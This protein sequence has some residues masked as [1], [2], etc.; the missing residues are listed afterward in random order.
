MAEYR[1]P[2]PAIFAGLLEAALEK[3]LVLDPLSAERLLRL[4]GRCLQVNLEGLGIGLFLT[5]ESGNLRVNLDSDR[6]PDTV[7]TATPSALFSMAAPGEP[8]DWG[9]P[10]SSVHITGDA[11]LARELERIFSKLEPDWQQPLNAVL[12]DT[13][14]FQVA[15]GLR[16]GIQAF[17][18]AAGEGGQ[19]AGAWLRDD[20]GLLAGAEELREFCNS[21]DVLSD[22]ADRLQARVDLL[23]EPAG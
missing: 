14:G 18:N 13:L 19:M 20:S 4:Q 5:F 23:K 15:S 11:G 3:V 6:E 1:T 2:L 12:G 16:Q 9:L 7:I 22:A 21:V 17:K 8:G 10:G